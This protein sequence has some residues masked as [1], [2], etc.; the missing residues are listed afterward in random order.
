MS[1]Q[2][3]LAQRFSAGNQRITRQRVPSGTAESFV[4]KGL[5]DREGGDCPTAKAL[6]YD[7]KKMMPRQIGYSPYFPSHLG[8]E[9]GSRLSS[10][11]L[12][13]QAI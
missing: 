5:G 4:R 13:E 9:S 2:L 6:G 12:R 3:K 1:F 7:Q 8:Q 10:E 11:N